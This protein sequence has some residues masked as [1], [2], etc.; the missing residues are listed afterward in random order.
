MQARRAGLH[1]RHTGVVGHEVPVGHEAAR[2]FT[3]EDDDREVRI[4][5][6]VLDERAEMGR[7]F[8]TPIHTWADWEE[9]RPG[10]VEIDPVGHEGGDPRGDFCQA[11][12]VT[13]VFTGWTET[14]AVRNKA[15]KWVFA[16]LVEI[17]A[18]FPFPIVGSP[19]EPGLRGRSG[20][21]NDA[22]GEVSDSPYPSKAWPPGRRPPPARRS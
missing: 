4:V 10:F 17:T 13:A 6:H 21:L 2:L 8:Q 22:T 12:A 15:Q 1:F 19:I 7:W 9:H 11:L 14:R 5:L 3:S 18:A 20:W 16:A